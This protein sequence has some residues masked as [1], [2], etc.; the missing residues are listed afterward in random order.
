MKPLAVNFKALEQLGKWLL[1]QPSYG[2]SE[3][4]VGPCD[5]IGFHNPHL[6]KLMEAM[7]KIGKGIKVPFPSTNEISWE[8]RIEKTHHTTPNW[9]YDFSANASSKRVIYTIYGPQTQYAFSEQKGRRR[10]IKKLIA[11]AD[12]KEAPRGT[13]L[14]IDNQLLHRSPP[15]NEPRVVLI[16]G[17][18]YLSTLLKKKE[19][20]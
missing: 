19:K 13:P 7:V 2:Y 3:Y 18:Y 12:I 16:A 11:A 10:V 14:I 20:A 15:G 8:L 5:L 17:F 6:W 1:E 4:S 9:H